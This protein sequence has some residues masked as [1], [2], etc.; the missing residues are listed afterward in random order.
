MPGSRGF[1]L[2]EVL[3]ALVILAVGL[4]GL[5]VLQM[6][7]LQGAHVAYQRTVASLAAQDAR[8]R[9]WYELTKRIANDSE[10]ACPADDDLAD[11]TAVGSEW[12][13]R[14]GT[15][16]PALA[17]DAIEPQPDC[18]FEITI[19]WT[20]DRFQEEGDISR[21]SY[22]FTLPVLKEKNS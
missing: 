15:Y 3:V 20:D 6:K 16:L 18:S 11:I 10:E 12:H 9:V 13:D 19:D 8:E 22:Q 1:S 4:L 7:S 21:L 2:V 17:I 14:W 5:A